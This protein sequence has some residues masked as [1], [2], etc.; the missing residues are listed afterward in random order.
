[1]GTVKDPVIILTVVSLFESSVFTFLLLSEHFSL[2][3]LSSQWLGFLLSVTDSISL[4]F[5]KVYVL[6][7]K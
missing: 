6:Y 4:I 1:M 5:H 7:N 2:P 3:L